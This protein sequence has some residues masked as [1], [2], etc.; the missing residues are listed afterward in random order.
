M[1]A[2]FRDDVRERIVGAVET[3]AIRLEPLAWKRSETR[4]AYQRD[5][6][7]HGRRPD[8]LAQSTAPTSGSAASSTDS[9]FVRSTETGA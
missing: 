1:T 7:P 4:E 5:W 3:I 6:E 2:G 9:A 8:L